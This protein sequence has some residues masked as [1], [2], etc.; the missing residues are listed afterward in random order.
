MSL[1]ENKYL[2]KTD[3]KSL[4][5]VIAD[6]E[7]NTAGEIRVVIRQRRHWKERKLSLHDLTLREFYR[8]GMQN[9]RDKTGV[10]ILLLLSERKF[11][12]I[13]DEGIHK[14]VEDGKWDKL[15][16]S[17]TD[18][19]KKGNYSEGIAETIRAVGDELSKH[20][21]RRPDDTDELSN[22]IIQQ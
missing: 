10:L 1:F 9:T 5:A 4:S 13:A 14:K 3:L 16:G 19:F 2:S 21:P 22:E 8:L 20:F 15:A 18:C 6:A 17:M 11:Q 12:I 7:K